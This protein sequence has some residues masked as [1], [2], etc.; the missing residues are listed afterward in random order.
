MALQYVVQVLEVVPPRS[1]YLKTPS[2]RPMLLWTDAEYIEGRPIGMG[3]VL[4]EQLNPKPSEVVGAACTLSEEVFR[5]FL[6]KK[7]HIAQGE[8]FVPYVALYHETARIANC[9]MIWF[10]DN[11]AA[12]VAL[13][14]G[15]STKEDI[16]MTTVAIHVLLTKHRIRVWIEYVESASNPSDGLSRDGVQ[17]EWTIR[18]GWTLKQVECPPFFSRQTAAVDS[19]SDLLNVWES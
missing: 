5:Q 16:M 19:L 6:L 7:Q 1:V 10:V 2:R 12:A 11:I 14:K 17:D 4:K 13:I 8:A 18:Q 15:A 9:D 3:Y